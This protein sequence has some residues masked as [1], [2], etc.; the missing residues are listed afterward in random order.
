MV[1]DKKILQDFRYVSLYKTG[2]PWVGTIFYPRAII[3]TIL[4]V[5]KSVAT[6]YQIR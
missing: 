3:W 1:P 2:D 5:E 6:T 4:V